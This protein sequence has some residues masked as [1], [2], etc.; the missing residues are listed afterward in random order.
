MASRNKKVTKYRK[1]LNINIGMVIFG[2]IFVYVVISI[3]LYA[4]N[5]HISVYEV[6]K[7]SLATNNTYHG[8]VLRSETKVTAENAGYINFYAREGEKIG[9]GQTVYTIDETGQLA[10]LLSDQTSSESTL[11]ND[12]INS[13]KTEFSSFSNN[14]NTTNFDELYNFKYDVENKVLELVNV[15]LLNSLADLNSENAG[16]FTTSSAP[17]EGLVVY[18]TDGYEEVTLDTLT[19]DMM[20]EDNYTKTVVKTSDLVNAGDVVYKLITDEAWS[21]IIPLDEDKAT[22]YA[23]KTVM[24]IKFKKDGVTANAAFSIIRINSKPY[25]KLDLSNSAIRY[26]SDRFIDVELVVSKIEGLKIPVSSIV[27]K[28]FYTIPIDYAT[29]GGDSNETGFLVETYDADGKAI[30]QFVQPTIYYSTDEDYYVDT[31]EFEAGNYIV[32][33]DSTERYPIGKTAKL[34]GV[35]SINKGYAQFKQI[36]ILFENEEYYIVEEGT[37][38]GIAVY[39]HIVLDGTAVQEDDIIY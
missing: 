25:G 36:N 9:A 22:E 1:P 4:I 6:N 16:V 20:N 2:I 29:Q 3:V 34:T 27:E 28:E 15:N 37:T 21:I 12:D 8:F 32:K 38:Y 13:L 26:A 18:S 11:S 14:F 35:Y 33:T 31:H 5:P 24:K 39:D 7:G 19:E 23:E 10:Q 30:T 17:R